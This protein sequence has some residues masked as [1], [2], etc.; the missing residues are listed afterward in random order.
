MTDPPRT[1]SQTIGP[2]FGFAL[3][4]PADAD[5]VAAGAPG[6]LRLRGRLLDGRG[7]PVTDGLVETWAPRGF[8]RCATD[9]D[10]RYAVR[11]LRPKAIDG[12]AGLIHAPHLLVSI[13]A[14]G[15]LRRLVTRVY[16]PGEEAA[17]DRDP[18]LANIGDA[19][20]RA[21][22]LATRDVAD[23]GG[24]PAAD[25]DERYT[26]DIRLQGADETLF[27]DV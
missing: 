13:F 4:G 24:A 16:F 14:R 7:D 2:F 20:A 26:F 21:T 18:V 6:A 15:L 5:P 22:L 3:P 1:P 8:A 19:A 17:N 12:G 11:T 10:G 9:R 25:V 27:F 23:T